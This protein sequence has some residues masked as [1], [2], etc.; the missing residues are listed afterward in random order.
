MAG[1]G[2]AWRGVFVAGVE[3]VVGMH[4]R[5]DAW[6]SMHGGGHTWQ[7]DVRGRYYGYG[8]RSMSGRYASYWNA[9][10][11]LCS[12]VETWLNNRLVLVSTHIPPSASLPNVNEVAGM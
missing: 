9:F 7:R 11:Y 8:I 12:F 1:G 10:L 5:G 4:C 3:C 6:G 2:R